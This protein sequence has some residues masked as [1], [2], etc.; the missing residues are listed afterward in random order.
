MIATDIIHW[1]TSTE[2]GTILVLTFS[3]VGAL[4]ALLYALLQLSNRLWPKVTWDDNAYQIIHNV[5]VKLS[6][7]FK[8]KDS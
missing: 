7:I 4:D 3:V 1:A 5:V 6:S 8:K 2:W